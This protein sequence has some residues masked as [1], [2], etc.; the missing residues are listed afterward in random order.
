MCYS[1]QCY[2]TAFKIADNLGLEKEQY[3]IGFQSRLGK[4][5]WTEPFTPDV[6]KKLRKKGMSKLLVFSPSFVADCLETTIE[7]SDEY[8][9]EWEEMGGEKLDLVPSLNDNPLW[10]E[11]I[12]DILEPHL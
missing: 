8:H 12:H 7:I 6:L 4:D 10:V 11:A 2:D 1:A 3:S 5:P 9:E